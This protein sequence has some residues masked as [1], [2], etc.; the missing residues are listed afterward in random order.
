MKRSE[1]VDVIRDIGIIP[2]VRVATADDAHFAVEAVASGGIPVVELTMTTPGCI[3]MIEHLV[4]HHP[5]MV[6]GA[7][8]VLDL[9]TARQCAD[10]GA[11]FLTAPGYECDILNFAVKRDIVAL[12]GALTPTEVVTA[13]R[14]GADFVKVFPC[15]QVGADSYIRALSRSLPQIPL[16]AAGGV[17]QQN[18]EAFILA[19]ATAIGVGTQLIP[20]EAIERRQGKRIKEL[21]LR[22]S[23]FVKEARERVPVKKLAAASASRISAVHCDDK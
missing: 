23:K 5:K 10:A 12:P 3:D 14:A 11:H 9:E 21:A 2:A 7:G 15:G 8:T 6:V 13:W 20:T 22:F 4:K 18:A 17:N 16:V 1:V 19:G